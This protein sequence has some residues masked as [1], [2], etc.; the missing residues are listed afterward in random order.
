MT[1]S[2][3]S[4]ATGRALWLIALVV[5]VGIPGCVELTQTLTISPLGSGTLVVEIA[6]DA[7]AALA[8]EAGGR[9]DPCPGVDI[10]GGSARLVERNRERVEGVLS[11]REVVTFGHISDVHLNGVELAL[12]ID[13]GILATRYRFRQ[14]IDANPADRQL[15][16]LGHD[17]D[18]PPALLGSSE[19]NLRIQLPGRVVTTNAAGFSAVRERWGRTATVLSWQPTLLDLM[20]GGL[21]LEAETER[22]NSELLIAAGAA[23]AAVALGGAL[24]FLRRNRRGRSPMGPRVTR[25]ESA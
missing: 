17:E 19:S 22:P 13:P 1:L 24:R 7:L 20:R 18:I 3:S 10:R 4:H 11:C 15:K 16:Q 23:G 9:F 5:A 2:R 25:A 6:V 14:Q 8:V 21:V 12:E